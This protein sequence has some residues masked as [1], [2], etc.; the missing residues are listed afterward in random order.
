MKKQLFLYIMAV[1]VVIIAVGLYSCQKQTG[2]NLEP[3]YKSDKKP[4][5][6]K[7]VQVNNFPGGA[8]IT[9]DIPADP[10]ILYVQADYMINQK[11]HQQVKASY[12][13]DTLKVLGFEKSGEYKVTLYAVSR[14][15]VK[16]DPV[17]VTVHPQTPPYLTVKSSLQIVADFGG[18][19]IQFRNVTGADIGVVTLVDTIGKP[20]YIY[21]NYTKD[22]SG[23]FSVRG[24]SATERK[25]GAF[26]RDRWG[27]V[28]DTVWAKV[29]SMNE[30][31][32]DRTKMKALVLPGDQT[33]CCGSNLGVP[34]SNAY[35]AGDWAFYG[36]TGPNDSVPAR[37]TIDFGRPVVLSRF[38]YW[39]R[40][41]GGAEFRNGTLRFFKIYGSMNPNPNGALDNTWTQIGGVYELVKPS[42][43]PYGQLNSAD[44]AVVDNGSEFIFPLPAVTMR[45]FRLVILQNF[46]GGQGLEM[47]SIKFMG[48]YK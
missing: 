6:V 1:T 33:A 18:A 36:G 30:Q 21:T 13:T 41:N 17:E 27:N 7:N 15:E 46:S 42:G 39:M 19:N 8:L 45:Y 10:E 29:T 11:M 28:S 12:Y 48:D 24:F 14:S 26:V 31:E 23:N 43:L 22:T 16:S 35:S 38:R 25:F 37:V 2:T 5:V 3:I 34:L 47:A 9:Y 44:N 20:E 40:Q 4:P 32:L